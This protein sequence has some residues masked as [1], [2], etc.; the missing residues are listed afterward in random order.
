MRI[1]RF[2]IVAAFVFFLLS[3]LL[4]ASSAAADEADNG[5]VEGT[6]FSPPNCVARNVSGTPKP[7]SYPEQLTERVHNG[8]VVAA[9]LKTMTID[10]SPY[11][12][13]NLGDGGRY[14]NFIVYL[15]LSFPLTP[16][17]FVF[18]YEASPIVNGM[19]QTNCPHGALSVDGGST[20]RPIGGEHGWSVCNSSLHPNQTA[21]RADAGNDTISIAYYIGISPTS[22]SLVLALPVRFDQAGCDRPCASS[23]PQVQWAIHFAFYHPQTDVNTAKT[24]FNGPGFQSPRRCFES[25][26]SC[27]NLLGMQPRL[28][29]VSLAP[30]VSSGPGTIVY[31]GNSD[32]LYAPTDGIVVAADRVNGTLTFT[33]TY[34]LFEIRNIRIRGGLASGSSVLAG[35]PVGWGSNP[36]LNI[37][38]AVSGQLSTVDLRVILTLDPRCREQLPLH[39]RPVSGTLWINTSGVAAWSALPGDP[40][41]A[42]ISGTVQSVQ[43]D[44]VII[45]S[46]L[47]L[48]QLVNVSVSS[49]L[50]GKLVN[51]GCQ[52]GYVLNGKDR[53]F[54]QLDKEV[55][56]NVGDIFSKPPSGGAC[57]YASCQRFVDPVSAHLE[58][59][60]LPGVIPPSE[61]HMTEFRAPVG[62]STWTVR[63]DVEPVGGAAGLELWSQSAATFTNIRSRQMLSATIA[64]SGTEGVVGYAVADGVG[65]IFLRAWGMPLRIHSLCL[66]PAG[67]EDVPQPGACP[68]PRADGWVAGGGD[69]VFTEQGTVRLGNGGWIQKTVTRI[70][71]PDHLP[72]WEPSSPPPDSPGGSGA[73]SF[74]G[75]S[76]QAISG[77]YPVRVLAKAMSGN[78]TLILEKRIAEGYWKKLA[79]A[80]IGGENYY[81]LVANFDEGQTYLTI[82][83]RASG[84]TVAIFEVCAEEETLTPPVAACAGARPYNLPPPS[85]NL[86]EQAIAFLP[87]LASKIHDYAIVPLLCRITYLYNTGWY[88]FMRN[89][90]LPVTQILVN[91][92]ELVREKGFEGLIEGIRILLDSLWRSVVRPG[93]TR[94]LNAL[95]NFLQPIIDFLGIGDYTFKLLQR[96]F[97]LVFEIM[98]KGFLILT[99]G[100]TTLIRSAWQGFRD[101]ID[102]PA[103]FPELP[104]EPVQIG[105]EL[106]GYA[107]GHM[108]IVPLT[109]VYTGLLMWKLFEFTLRVLGWVKS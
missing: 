88:H 14:A 79:E 52:I 58:R 10:N 5:V 25:P 28:F 39:T 77:I 35:C 81:E 84:G 97:E 82:R 8:K 105:F 56:P 17:Q 86:I 96:L 21:F 40:V 32:P 57:R 38:V 106:I 27:P 16:T 65:T 80:V 51:E 55:Y 107:L 48:I 45:S 47:A 2:W 43:S 7:C 4:S 74:E 64:V 100:L 83:L 24:Y 95:L 53:V 6:G 11:D 108:L 87:W 102:R 68:A 19:G 31:S 78:P 13:P 20:F 29:K 46:S 66:S 60:Y 54:L 103:V 41:F 44:R 15:Y 98:R 93:L 94:L 22:R 61:V 42:P 91:I 9:E 36:F 18:G 72:P 99:N 89:V 76:G 73:T 104:P 3:F 85:G 34:G 26:S 49:D 30:V 37:P 67:R 62:V 23:P 50:R 101:A 33:T 92:R 63:A 109:V 12:P 70:V 59:V 1:G 71:P 90:Y 75:P 69:V